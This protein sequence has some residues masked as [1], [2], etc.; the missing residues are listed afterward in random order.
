MP[1]STVAVTTHFPLRVQGLAVSADSV[2]ALLAH[3]AVLGP[4]GV[5]VAP[6]REESRNLRARTNNMTKEYRF[7]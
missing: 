7:V 3:V 6:Y 4:D 2:A 5:A 1:E